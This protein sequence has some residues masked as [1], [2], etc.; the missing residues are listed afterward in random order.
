MLADPPSHHQQPTGASKRTGTEP[1]IEECLCVLCKD[2]LPFRMPVK[3]LDAV[4]TGN[5]V[6][7]AGAG[8]S[9]E[10]NNVYP[11]SFYQE[12][13]SELGKPDA[14]EPF[15]DLM[16]EYCRRP[17]GRAQ[18][19]RKINHRLRHTKGFPDLYRSATE[20]HRTV[21]TVWQLSDIV[22]TNWDDYFERECEAVPFVSPEDFTFWSL[23]GRRVL[24][25]HGSVTSLGSLIVTREDYDRCTKQLRT[26]DFLFGRPGA[27]TIA[28]YRLR[29]NGFRTAA[30]FGT[31]FAAAPAFECWPI[32]AFQ[33]SQRAL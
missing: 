12:V 29:C 8:I 1:S 23:P 22:T 31:P 4:R 6:L 20:F 16:S 11:Y 33:R 25:I 15:P 3:L 9:T 10:R 30:R 5:L 2:K 24:K 17:D 32:M 14:T 27:Y 19:L 28:D 13:A 18:L 7:F 21:S 26:Q